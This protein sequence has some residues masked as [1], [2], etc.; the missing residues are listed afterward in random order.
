MKIALIGASGFIGSALLHEALERGHNLSAVVTRPEKL[1]PHA[2]LQVLACDVLDTQKL[3]TMLRGHDAILSAFSG[4]AQPN[5]QEYYEQG[6]RSIINA[7]KEA[8]VSRLLVV[9][10]AGSLE[11]APGKLLLDTDTFPK[12]HQPTAQGAYAALRLLREEKGLD[13]TMLSPAAEIFPGDKTGVFRL[14]TDQLLQDAKG[15]SRISTADYAVA[16]LNE[17][18]QPAH[19]R[20]RFTVAY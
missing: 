16:M 12:E 14:G 4:H 5:V 20:R 10:G 17:L 19:I 8:G 9:G 2:Q 15:Q 18:E 13:W 11:V 6:I 7:S 3:A 1:T